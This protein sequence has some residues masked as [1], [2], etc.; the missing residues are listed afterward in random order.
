MSALINVLILFSF[1]AHGISKAIKPHKNQQLC[2][3][4]H[5]NFGKTHFIVG[6]DKPIQPTDNKKQQSS[7]QTEQ[8]SHSTKNVLEEGVT[9]VFF[10]SRDDKS[11]D[12][13]NAIS[14]AIGK[15]HYSIRVAAFA[16]TDPE[17][18][19]QLK[20]A[21]ESGI[22]VEIITD[23]T[24]MNEQ[25]SK[26]NDLIS[27]NIPVWHYG[28]TNAKQKNSRYARMHHKFMV[29]DD[30]C[31]LTGSANYT[32]AGQ[33]HNKENIVTIWEKKIIDGY[34]KQFDELKTECIPCK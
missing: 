13:R 5:N 9:Q 33:K 14:E 30:K 31:V 32:K 20:K 1:H 17:I 27:C 4:T 3:N 25:Y 15:A 2:L 23:F 8:N 28:S 16:L 11:D 22:T 18:T 29:I 6:Y 19:A 10:T 12:I 24:N 34:I 26:I 7:P 21:A